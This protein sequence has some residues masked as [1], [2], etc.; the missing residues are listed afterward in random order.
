MQTTDCSECPLFEKKLPSSARRGRTPI[1]RPFRGLRRRPSQNMVGLL[2]PTG[3]PAGSARPE[4]LS[5]RPKA[6]AAM[7]EFEPWFWEASAATRR[8]LLAILL[9]S[10]SAAI[11]QTVWMPSMWPAHPTA[12]LQQPADG[13]L[14]LYLAYWSRSSRNDLPFGSSSMPAWMPSSGM[15]VPTIFILHLLSRIM[16]NFIT[17][18][19]GRLERLSLATDAEPP[20][21]PVATTHPLAPLMCMAAGVFNYLCS[22]GLSARR[23]WVVV[24]AVPLSLG[25]MRRGLDFRLTGTSAACPDRP[26]WP[27]APRPLG[28]HGTWGG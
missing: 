27:A 6:A 2:R 4:P 25:A 20:L 9:V 21:S 10:G 15:V 23:R 3:M 26:S 16:L 28:P 22:V 7:T 1:M 17:V 18:G 14:M 24:L 13:L 19:S 11:A 8:V 12:A 5:D